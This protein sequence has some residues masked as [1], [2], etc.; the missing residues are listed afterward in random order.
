MRSFV[1]IL[2]LVFELERTQQRTNYHTNALTD[3]WGK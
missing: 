1:L 2:T 3:I